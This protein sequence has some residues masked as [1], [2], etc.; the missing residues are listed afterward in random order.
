MARLGPRKATT[1]A[2]ARTEAVPDGRGR[3]PYLVCAGA[4]EDE[5]RYV[6]CDVGLAELE[7]SWPSNGR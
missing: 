1:L 7:R 4:T 3:D 6:V 2:R 5:D